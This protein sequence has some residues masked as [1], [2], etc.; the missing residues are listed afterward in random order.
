MENIRGVSFLGFYIFLNKNIPYQPSKLDSLRD[1]IIG[2][3]KESL[4]LSPVPVSNCFWG[5][6]RLSI[7]PLSVP[8]GTNLQA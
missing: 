8:G 3:E 4:V 6:D 5:P 1:C 2:G 7:S